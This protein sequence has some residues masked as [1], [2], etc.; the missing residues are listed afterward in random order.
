VSGAIGKQ[1]VFRW[2]LE[3]ALPRLVRKGPMHY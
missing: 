2:R 1:G 3:D